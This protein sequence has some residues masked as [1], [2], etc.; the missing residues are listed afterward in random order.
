[1]DYAIHQKNRY[2]V[3]SV[4]KTKYAIY[5]IVIYPVDSAIHHSNNMGLIS[6]LYL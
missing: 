4:D 3:I 1:M 6:K 2:P 5:W